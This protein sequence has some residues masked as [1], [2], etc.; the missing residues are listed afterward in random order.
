V[1]EPEDKREQ[2]AGDQEEAGQVKRIAISD[3]VGLQPEQGAGNGDGSKQE[4]DEECPAPRGVG[5]EDAPEQ[6]PQRAARAG[7]GAVEP[8]GLARSPGSV[9]VVVKRAS[10]EGASKAPNAPWTVRAMTSIAKLTEAPPMAEA[11]AKPTSPMMRAL[12][13]PNLSPMRPPRRSKLPKVR[14]YAVTIH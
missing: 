4:V 11:A 1:G 6:Q 2:T 10:T 14:E 5:G 8:E 12:L 13:R 7:D 9:K 3:L